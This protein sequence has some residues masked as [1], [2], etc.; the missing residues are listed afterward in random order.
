MMDAQQP[1]DGVTTEESRVP[2]AIRTVVV[3]PAYN[4]ARTLERT[5]AD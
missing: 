3:M 5:V 2:E 1:I 4:A